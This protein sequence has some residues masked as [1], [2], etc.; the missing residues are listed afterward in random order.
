MEIKNKMK[1]KLLKILFFVNKTLRLFTY[2]EMLPIIKYLR[3]KGTYSY[4]EIPEQCFKSSRNEVIV[5]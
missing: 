3:N 4:L 2:Q 1:L 5:R